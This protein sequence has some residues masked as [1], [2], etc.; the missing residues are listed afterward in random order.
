M[1]LPAISN[2]SMVSPVLPRLMTIPARPKFEIEFPEMVTSRCVGFGLF[3]TTIRIPTS[4][5]FRAPVASYL[6]RRPD[7]LE[8][9]ADRWYIDVVAYDPQVGWTDDTSRRGYRRAR[10]PH[11]RR[12]CSLRP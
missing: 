1:W 12:S 6:D 4:V 5:P 10:C 11:R 2:P 8:V 9:D 3:V 7:V